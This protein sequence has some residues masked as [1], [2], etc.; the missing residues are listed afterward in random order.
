MNDI[1]FGNNNQTVLK[2]LS[3]RYFKA[4]KNRNRIAVIAIVLTTTLFAAIFTLGFGMM[5]TIHDQNIRKA[6][7]D[8]QAVLSYINDN[9]Y[10]D[11][12]GSPLIDRI[13][14]TK[15]IS[16]KIKNPG[17]E[18]WRAEVWYMDDTMLDFARYEPTEGQK[19]AADR[20]IMADTKTLEA[21][22]IPA[23]IGETVSLSY[24][25]KGKEYQ[26][27]FTLCGFWETDS[28]SH[29][30]RLL[31]S[32]AFM[33]SHAELDGYTHTVGGD[34][35]GSV[36]SY[37]MFKGNGDPETKLQQLLS[38]TGYTCDTM[39]GSAEDPNYIIARISPAYTGGNLLENPAMLISGIAGILLIIVA[40][41]LIIY[42]IFQISVIQDIQS[43]GQL[44]TLGI[45]KRQIKR[46]ISGQVL[47]L[48]L[49][50]IPI[51]LLFGFLIG[52][53]L[54]PFLMNGTSYTSEAG[55][56]V[57]ANPYIFIGSA[58][59]ALITVFISV[60]RPARIAGMVSPIEAIRYTENDP[61]AFGKK[62]TDKKST[63][64][65]KIHRMALANLGRNRRR[66]V[67]VLVS[68]TLSLV[69][70]N[71][72]FTAALILTNIFQNLWMW[73]F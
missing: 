67:L 65:A 10:E 33:D 3:G 29:V 1:L 20:E 28:L 45:T 19:P 11:V 23:R 38:E 40:G 15:C 21:L 8:G 64:G 22:G 57:T 7:G 46:L 16:Y 14:Y 55:I 27:D 51:G 66:T 44:K 58:V 34:Y 41:Y 37:I 43:Y 2:R 61:G 63:K 60:R 39:G 18:K 12:K 36:A 25:M 5:D 59:F 56:K 70:F 72:V 9:I 53:A 73:I 4:N 6:G 17:L 47:R 24:E 13:A 50:G 71:T 69:L 49:I 62:S 54:V 32:K 42:N 52:R 35:T 48:S 30:G 31:V 68:M 26:T